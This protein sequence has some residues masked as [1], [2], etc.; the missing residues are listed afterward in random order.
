[1]Q[2]A[3]PDK[4]VVLYE[5]S[6]SFT[7]NSWYRYVAHSLRS[8]ALWAY[9]FWYLVEDSRI[10]GLWFVAPG[11]HSPSYSHMPSHSWL[12]HSIHSYYRGTIQR[13]L[14]CSLLPHDNEVVYLNIILRVA[15]TLAKAWVWAGIRVCPERENKTWFCDHFTIFCSS[16]E[17]VEAYSRKGCSNLEIPPALIVETHIMSCGKLQV[18]PAVSKYSLSI[19]ILVLKSQQSAVHIKNVDFI[20]TSA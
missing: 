14:Y 2:F 13:T 11:H 1:M 12:R 15:S 8:R 10:L 20:L 18:S 7:I 4:A 3:F 17:I 9:S 6:H 16:Y 5:R 19:L